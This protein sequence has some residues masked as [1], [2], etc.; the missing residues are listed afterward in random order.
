MMGFFQILPTVVLGG[1]AGALAD[2]FDRR[3]MML[4]A[5]LGFIVSDL[6]LLAAFVSGH[7]Q[8]WELYAVT[9][10]SAVFGTLQR[11]A[12]QASVAMLVPPGQRDRANALGQLTGPV[13][14][15][16]AP[17]LGGLLYAVIGVTGA[18]CFDLAT[19]AAAVAV[20][21]V[22][23]IPRPPQTAEGKAMRAPVWRQAFDGFRYLGARPPLLTLCIFYALV[24][25][26]MLGGAL[27]VATPY[28][29]ARA[30]GD[31]LVVGLIFSAL[32]CG[33]VTGALV[34]TAWGGTR[35]RV[36]TVFP[37]VAI[38]GVF[39]ALAGAAQTPVTVA[40]VFFLFMFTIPIANA[41]TMSI[42]QAKIAPD[43]QGRVFAAVAQINGLL[44]PLVYLAMGPLADKVFEPARRAP[45][46]RLFGWAFGDAPG[47]G[48]GLMLAIGGALAFVTA[49]A[50]YAVPAMRRIES[51]LPDFEAAEAAAA[52]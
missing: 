34:M 44:T 9:F 17:S 12:A 1:F 33:A 19:F 48:M 32:H 35:P 51:D 24:G 26:V 20:L 50:F 14:R 4:I 30:H 25:G 13:S 27:L 46:W 5:N 29:F 43:L 49:L 22:V 11:P 6:L 21:A 3:L 7:F 37:G 16:I 38:Q 47:A 52:A 8:L 39:L 45:V 28:V 10:V 31:P 41:A 23:R 2:R 42:F 36:H 15:V 40:A 18:I